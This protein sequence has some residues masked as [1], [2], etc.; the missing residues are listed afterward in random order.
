MIATLM[1]LVYRTASPMPIT[2][3]KSG[4]FHGGV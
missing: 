2:A 4:A 1:C 3:A